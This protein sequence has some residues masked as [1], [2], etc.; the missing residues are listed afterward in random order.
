MLVNP[1]EVLLNCALTPLGT[2]FVDQFVVVFQLLSVVPFQMSCA[3]AA[4]AALN[5][6]N[7]SRLKTPDANVFFL[8]ALAR[9]M[10]PPDQFLRTHTAS[11][12]GYEAAIAGR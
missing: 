4:G 12:G 2:A 7:A 5:R 3:R 11:R 10:N 6:T 9:N 1:G 8:K